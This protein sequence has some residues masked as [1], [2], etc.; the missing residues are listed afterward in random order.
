MQGGHRRLVLVDDVSGDAQRLLPM[1]WNWIG[2]VP[3]RFLWAGCVQ[4]ALGPT[5]GAT[6]L[7]SRLW[8]S[9]DA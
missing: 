5:S 1:G 6:N 2:I 9:G 3:S 7:T 8:R 4:A